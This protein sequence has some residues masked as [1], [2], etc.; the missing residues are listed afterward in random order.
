MTRA[1]KQHV[2]VLLHTLASG[3]PELKHLTKTVFQRKLGVAMAAS[4]A[5]EVMHMTTKL[6]LTPSWHTVSKDI[7]AT[8]D[9]E[10][11]KDPGNSFKECGAFQAGIMNASADNVDEKVGEMVVVV[12]IRVSFS[13]G[14]LCFSTGGKMAHYT[15][16][17]GVEFGQLRAST[18]AMF[19]TAAAVPPDQLFQPRGEVKKKVILASESIANRPIPF[20]AVLQPNQRPTCKR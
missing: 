16:V 1:D 5:R 15:H 3:H 17:Q 12:F 10:R 8:A 4:S 13:P 18:K 19:A 20:K 9:K 11:A 6:G 7:A 14:L 2:L